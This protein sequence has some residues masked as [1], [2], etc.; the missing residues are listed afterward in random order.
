MWHF[1]LWRNTEVHK[2]KGKEEKSENVKE[3]K[4]T[5]PNINTENE[6][7]PDA[8]AASGSEPRMCFVVIIFCLFIWLFIYLHQ[9]WKHENLSKWSEFKSKRKWNNAP[10]WL[11]R[12]LETRN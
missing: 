7:N 8:T 12:N 3:P 5:D 11:I 9:K 6:Q 2:D 10:K 1:F 4:K